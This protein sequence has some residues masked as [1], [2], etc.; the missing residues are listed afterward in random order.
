GGPV[1]PPWRTAADTAR[2]HRLY[3]SISPEDLPKTSAQSDRRVR[4]D[5][6]LTAR[7]KGVMDFQIVSYKSD[8][9][10]LEIPAYV[11]SPLKH[12]GARGHAAIVWIHGYVH[13]RL[14]ERHLPF[15]Q[16]AVDRGYVVVAPNYRGS[17]GYTNEFADMIDY[18]GKE[19]DDAESAYTYIKNSLG[20][21]D[22]D[23]VGVIGWSH[24]GFITSHILFRDNQ[25][26]KAGVANVPVTNLIF[27]L[28]THQPN[29]TQPFASNPDIG[30]MPSDRTCG[31]TRDSACV[32]FYVQRSPVFHVAN[33]RVPMMVS[34]ATNDCDVDF[35][36][37]Q[38]MVFTL[39]ALKPE[40]ADTK[41]YTNPPYLA[42][43]STGNRYEGR[44]PQ[45][46]GGGVLGGC[47]HTFTERVDTDPKSPTYLQ[48]LDSPEQIDVWNRT[49]AFFEKH[50]RPQVGK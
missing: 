20:Y 43:D 40:L 39:R 14:D 35:I 18:G 6:I 29:Y 24:G 2:A 23:R 19:I 3:I 11:F 36:E 37:D 10:G 9:D 31:K 16:E 25:P 27:R 38:Q 32:P 41:I 45:K 46:D 48:R 17:L 21:V 7:T 8:I 34:V 42:A 15:I 44:D 49:W 26:F 13:G 1:G 33:L 50:L 4:T 47:G 22:P 12:R 30:G 28:S 5:S